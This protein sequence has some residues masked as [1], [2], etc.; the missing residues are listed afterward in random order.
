MAQHRLSILNWPINGIENLKTISSLKSVLYFVCLFV[1]FILL[2]VH[3][4]L[5]HLT[6]ST[7]LD[8]IY[9]LKGE[10]METIQKSCFSGVFRS[11][12][13][14]RIYT[15]RL[16]LEVSDDPYPF[17]K[18]PQRWTLKK[19][20]LPPPVF[21]LFILIGTVTKKILLHPYCLYKNIFV[22]L[23]LFVEINTIFRHIAPSKLDFK[24]FITVLWV[25]QSERLW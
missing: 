3:P 17:F 23:S 22:D 13:S 21:C 2:S 20:H 7:F 5:T 6:T 9:G 1:C 25:T 24:T 15:G 18:I 11:T 12:H 19:V 14:T 4:S 10:V 16:H 8:W